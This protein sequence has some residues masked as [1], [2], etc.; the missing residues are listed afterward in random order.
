MS[1]EHKHTFEYEIYDSDED[2]IVDQKLTLSLDGDVNLRG[3]LDAFQ[4]YLE[5]AGFVINGTVVIQHPEVSSDP[6]DGEIEQ[7]E[8]EIPPQQL[9]DQIKSRR[10]MKVIK[11]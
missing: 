11:N 4:S 6:A 7:M 5:G 1:F 9:G 10:T 8:L 3:I 2:D